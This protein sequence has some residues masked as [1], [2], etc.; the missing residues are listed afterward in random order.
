MQRIIFAHNITKITGSTMYQVKL[1]PNEIAVFSFD[2]NTF[3]GLS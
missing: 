3:S 1:C 2:K